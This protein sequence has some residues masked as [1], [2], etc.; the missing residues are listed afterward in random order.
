MIV[1]IVGESNSGKTHLLEYLSGELTSRGI[2]VSSIKHVHTRDSLVPQGK[3]TTRHLNAGSSPVLGISPN[4]TVLYYNKS[5]DLDDAFSLLQ[6]IAQPDIILVEGFKKSRIPKIVIGNADAEEP[7]LLRCKEATDCWKRAIELIENEIKIERILRT[8]PQ[9]NCGK[10]GHQNCSEMASAIAAR[11]HLIE[12]CR[13]RAEVLVRLYADGE[14]IPL[15]RFVSNLISN[16]VVGMVQSLKRV[17]SPKS[18]II[19]I[20][21]KSV[22]KNEKMQED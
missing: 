1:A 13:N 2:K 8:L 12:N 20:Q 3:D 18:I 6:K 4:E 22:R 19:S 10:C 16:I 15:N 21:D 17:D 7:I 9:L 5:L 11:T 14:E